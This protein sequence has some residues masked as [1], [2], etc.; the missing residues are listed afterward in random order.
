MS[1]ESNKTIVY[2][3]LEVAN[4][5]GVVNQTAINWIRNGY[6]RAF[7]TPGG[8]YR[9]YLDDLVDCMTKRK[10]RIPEELLQYTSSDKDN[11]N[12][13]IVDDDKGLN[14]V[15][16]KF[17]EREMPQAKITQVYNGFDAG[18]ELAKKTT[19]VVLLDLNLPGVDGYDICHRIN[20]SEK[21]GKPSVFVI[22]ASQDKETEDKLT[23]MGAQG[24]FKKPLDLVKI[25]E[26]V[27]TKL[28]SEK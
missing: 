13:L 2:S 8:Q 21:F 28:E 24:F 3:A 1:K 26:A 16:S 15:L 14:M 17:F 11:V 7:C 12:I 25:V 19:N 22:T 4:I 10:M 5:C 23:R 20:T 27:K 18:A 6:L 9:V